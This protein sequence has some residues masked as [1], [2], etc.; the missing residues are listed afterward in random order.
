MPSLSASCFLTNGDARSSRPLNPLDV[1]TFVARGVVGVG[2]EVEDEDSSEAR[3]PRGKSAFR[4]LPRGDGGFARAV[5]AR[6]N[7]RAVVAVVAR[8]VPRAARDAREGRFFRTRRARERRWRRARAECATTTR[9]FALFA[10]AA[11]ARR[12]EGH[13]IQ[14]RF[15]G[16]LKVDAIKC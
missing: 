2:L 11:R 10:R 9:R 12:T 5:V 3:R 4:I 14:K 7:P 6:A 1:G 13:S 16:Q 8:I 15:T